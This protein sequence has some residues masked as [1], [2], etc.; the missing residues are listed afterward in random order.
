MLT[1]ADKMELRSRLNDAGAILES[2]MNDIL[3]TV[4]Q[5][6]EE[7]ISSMTELRAYPVRFDPRWIE[8]LRIM[9]KTGS[10]ITTNEIAEMLSGDRMYRKQVVRYFVYARHWKL[11][12]KTGEKYKGSDLY[13]LTPEAIACLDKD[14]LTVQASIWTRKGV[15]VAPPHGEQDGAYIRVLPSVA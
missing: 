2:E 15:R 8:C 1:D 12:K 11:I 6:I 5:F 13:V 10:P 3:H 14:E 7:K 9:K 4:A